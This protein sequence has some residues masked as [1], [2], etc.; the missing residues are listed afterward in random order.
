MINKDNSLRSKVSISCLREKKTTLLK[1][2]YCDI[3][4]KVVHYGSNRLSDHLEVMVMCYSP[5]V[6]DGD[7]LELTVNCTANS[8][9]KL[10]TQSFNKL[11]PMKSGARQ[12]AN[13]RVGKEALFQYLPHPTIPFKD[14]IFETANEIHVEETGHL[15]WGDI[16]SGGRIYSGEKFEF[17]KVH[18]NTKIYY[19]KKLIIH[20]NQLLEPAS[21]PISD[22]LFFEG[23]TH[24]AT[25]MIVSSTAVALKAELDEMLIEQLTD[26]RYGFT[27]CNPN[28][29]M[30][31]AL[32]TSGD[33]I[34]EWLGKL[35][36]MCFSF[37][38]FANGQ[39]VQNTHAV[40]KR[41]IPKQPAILPTTRAKVSDRNPRKKK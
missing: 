4:Y 36:H 7:S 12:Y 2:S 29:I 11:H 32:G 39:K 17:S 34:Y 38:Q 10:F 16:I 6:M 5:G 13:I 8:E 26:L 27:L 24:Q 18:S 15:I 9:M 31:R 40:P 1:D 30:L 35:S 37:I 19:G 22:M 25:L 20:D 33:A 3:P 23:F 14:S 41:V 28:S 21:Q